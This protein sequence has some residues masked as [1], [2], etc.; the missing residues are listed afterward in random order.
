MK[1]ICI[2]RNYH[3]HAK[4]LK[5]PVPSEPVFFLK[6][7]TALQINNRPFFYPDFSNNIH[8]EIEVVLKLCKTGR[9]IEKG[10]ATG[11]IG[12][13]GLGIDFT[14]RDLQDELK[15]KGLPWEKSKAFDFAA[16]V[17]QFIPVSSL[18]D[19]EKISF[20]LNK[21]GQT[22]Q[23]GTTSDL[24]FGFDEIISFVSKFITLRAGDLIFT[25]TPEGVGP[26]VIGDRLEGY[27]NDQ[28][29]LDFYIR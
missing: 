8:H 15:Q 17:S 16:P 26:V 14:A 7:D 10:F 9:K 11:Y 19:L 1:I 6:P 22:V 18:R 4:E 27:L 29:M 13:V 2:G 12:H 23:N 28:K 3:E 5:N 25:G 24:I 21:N 20:R